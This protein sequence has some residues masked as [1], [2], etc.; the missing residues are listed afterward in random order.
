MVSPFKDDFSVDT[1]AAERITEL[2]VTNDVIPFVLGTTGE[3][4]SMTS[5]QKEEL[6]RAVIRVTDGRAQVFAG[7]TSNS[8]MDSIYQSG[9]YA[10]M[11]VTAV[12]SSI[13]FYYPINESQILLYFEKLA[14]AVPCPLILYNIPVTVKSSIPLEIIDKLSNHPNISGV[15]DSEQNVER[16]DKSLNLWKNRT[17]FSYLLGWGA[18]SV[19][20]LKKGADG[21]VPSAGNVIPGLHAELYQAVVHGDIEKAEKLQERIQSVSKLYIADRD[22]GQSLVALKMLMYVKGLCGPEV[23]PPLFRMEPEEEQKFEN[24]IRRN[25]ELLGV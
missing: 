22:L 11:G 25:F 15:K 24:T 6:V 12:V 14:D 23:L 2:L 9:K 5:Q 16:I 19:Y 17:D 4:H 13:P 3:A 21:I 7:I 8:L 1:G 20:G 10:E 18:M